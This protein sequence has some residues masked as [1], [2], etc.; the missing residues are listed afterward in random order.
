MAT[1]APNHTKAWFPTFRTRTGLVEVT[2]TAWVPKSRAA[3]V[4][5]AIAPQS[6]DPPRSLRRIETDAPPRPAVTKSTSPS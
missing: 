3:G 4:T 5:H 6:T 1:V 2:P